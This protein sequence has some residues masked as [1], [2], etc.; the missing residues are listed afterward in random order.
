VPAFVSSFIPAAGGT[1]D[2]GD[3]DGVIGLRQVLSTLVDP[4]DR[5]GFAATWPRS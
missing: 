2:R 5:R 3:R 4:R 1:L